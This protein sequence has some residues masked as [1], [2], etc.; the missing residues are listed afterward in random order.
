MEIKY[1]YSSEQLD[2]AVKF[3]AKHNKT[4]LRQKKYIRDQIIHVM[5]KLIPEFGTNYTSTMGFTILADREVEN[6][7]NNYYS[8]NVQI[9]VDPALGIDVDDDDLIEDTIISP[10]TGLDE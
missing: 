3:I 6:I 8:C 5:N 9:L 4:F 7:D 1:S 2:L 10:I